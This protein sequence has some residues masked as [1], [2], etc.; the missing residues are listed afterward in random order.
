MPCVA[1]L[2]EAA[3]GS[4]VVGNKT[5]LRA[6]ELFEACALDLLLRAFVLPQQKPNESSGP[7]RLDRSLPQTEPVH[8]CFAAAGRL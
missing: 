3:P 1:S 8:L 4:G 5:I 7:T 2:D 6:A